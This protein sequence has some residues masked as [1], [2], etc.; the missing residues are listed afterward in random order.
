MR[1]IETV[2]ALVNRVRA[3]AADPLDVVRSSLALAELV[4]D[5]LAELERTRLLLQNSVTRVRGHI[6][7]KCKKCDKAFK[8]FHS[9][10]KNGKVA[11]KFCSRAC[12]AAY[13]TVS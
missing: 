9:H 13:R 2:E 11:G 1:L 10:I 4:P 6:D 12:Y 7:S 8:V 3:P 5:L